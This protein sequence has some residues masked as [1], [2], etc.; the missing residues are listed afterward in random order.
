MR[1]T[2]TERDRLP[3]FTAAESARAR[4]PR[5]LP[6]NVPEAAAPLADTVCEAARNGAR[7]AAAIEAGRSVLGVTDVLPGRAATR[8]RPGAAGRPCAA[9]AGSVRRR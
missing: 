8:C 1:P 7:P 5:G 2:P 6:R 9:R 4:R 3:I